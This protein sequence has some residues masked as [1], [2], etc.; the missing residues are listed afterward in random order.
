MAH[1]S[2]VVT[3]CRHR[4]GLMLQPVFE[5]SACRICYVLAVSPYGAV[6]HSFFSPQAKLALQLAACRLQGF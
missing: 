2:Y 5:H 4:S 1:I 3:P 6:S